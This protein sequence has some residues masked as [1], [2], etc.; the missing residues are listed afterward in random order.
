MTTSTPEQT[1]KS[2][3]A[4]GI[5]LTILSGLSFAATGLVANAL[6]D[7]GSSGVVVGFYEAVFGLVLI[8][9]AN[10]REVSRRPKMTRTTLGWTVL[11]AAGFA[12]AFGTFYTALATMDYSVGAPILGA[13]P[14]VSYAV[15]LV[16]LRGQEHI[17]RRALVGAVLVVAG[18]GIIGATS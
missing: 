4:S 7:D 2:T 1:T 13:I 16:L 9:A 8:V 12:T 17:T 15:A 14:L 18:V 5:V 6:V 3:V 11:A 10:V